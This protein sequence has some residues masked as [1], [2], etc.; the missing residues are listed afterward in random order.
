MPPSSGRDL[1]GIELAGYPTA[2]CNNSIALRIAPR[3]RSASSDPATWI[4]PDC[5]W[6]RV[7]AT[8]GAAGVAGRECRLPTGSRQAA[9]PGRREAGGCAGAG[10]GE[11]YTP[12]AR[13]VAAERA[14]IQ[15]HI[16]FIQGREYLRRLS[17]SVA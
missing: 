16:L 14:L 15:C 12:L 11:C 6:M 1:R 8:I 13:T 4:L 10:F 9:S 3:S 2:A 5:W 7:S 17:P